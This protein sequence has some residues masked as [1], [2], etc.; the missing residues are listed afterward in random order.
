[1]DEGAGVEIS[2][3]HHD[4]LRIGE[5]ILSRHDKSYNDSP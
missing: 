2:K 4:S 3:R 1:M 5:I